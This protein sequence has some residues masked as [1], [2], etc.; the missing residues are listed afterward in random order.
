[1]VV[2]IVDFADF[3]FVDFAIIKNT[4]K[5]KVKYLIFKILHYFSI[6]VSV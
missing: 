4:K 5:V 6:L 2:Y 1:M 3:R